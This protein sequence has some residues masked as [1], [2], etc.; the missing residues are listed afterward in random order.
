[1][2]VDLVSL[3]L[4]VAASFISPILSALIPKR[5]VPE[6]VV[7]LIAG[8]VIGPNVLNI[9]QPDAAIDL[10]SDLGL[11]FL[12]LL[13]GY[14]IDPKK[15]AGREAKIGFATWMVTF[16]IAV[17]LVAL[18]SDVRDNPIAWFAVAIALTTTAYGTLV[19]ILRERGITGTRI[20]D[21]ILSYG[22]WGEICPIIAIALVL[23]V[24][25]TWMTLAV[26]TVFAIIAIA[27]AVIPKKLWDKG[28]RLSNFIKSNAETSSQMTLRA[29]LVLLVGLLTVSSFFDLDIVLGSFVAGF[30]LRYIIPEGDMGLEHKLNGMGY[31]FFIPLFF[32]VSGMAISPEAVAEHPFQLVLFIVALLF[33][34]ALPIF[35]S[36]S[37]NKDTRDLDLGSK[38][39]VSLYCTTALPLIV[40]VVTIATN[41]GAMSADMG[42]N[43]IAAGGISVLLMPFGAALTME[44][45][46][47]GEE[48]E[49]N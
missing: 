31:G 9:A 35:T 4:I 24:R 23:S 37:I 25:T 17:G 42:S 46:K 12:F 28:A 30:I 49:N 34:R 32:V 41:A 45:F 26:L 27:I 5:Y 16:A 8:M 2:Q 6:T 29:V 43:L 44:I 47:R 13:A 48:R 19:P 40:A 18:D 1:M 15:L 20:G 10:L 7:L 3:L 21:S 22:I 38:T 11:G 33:V 14:E 36:L 39:T